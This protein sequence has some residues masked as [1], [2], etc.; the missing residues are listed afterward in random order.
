MVIGT[1]HRPMGQP[2]YNAPSDRGPQSLVFLFCDCFE[3][4]QAA[5]PAQD[6]P[7]SGREILEWAGIDDGL[8]LP[9]G[10]D[11]W[12][13]RAWRQSPDRRDSTDLIMTPQAVQALPGAQVEQTLEAPRSQKC[14]GMRN[15]TALMKQMMCWD[16]SPGPRPDSCP[17]GDPLSHRQTATTAPCQ[18]TKALGALTMAHFRP[19]SA[20]RPDDIS[21][22][23]P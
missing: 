5:Q 1:S 23:G 21:H 15:G 3:S 13:T 8:S 10:T 18:P 16:D 2:R 14:P 17:R 12:K 4:T 22:H 6:L 11:S 9:H 19:C 20:Q 7:L